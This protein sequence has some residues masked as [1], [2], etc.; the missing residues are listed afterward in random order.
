MGRK[1][2]DQE[3]VKGNRKAKFNERKVCDTK[4]WRGK[5]YAAEKFTWSKANDEEN[6]EDECHAVRKIQGMKNSSSKKFAW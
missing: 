3:M 5:I 6:L 4:N 1:N 2:H